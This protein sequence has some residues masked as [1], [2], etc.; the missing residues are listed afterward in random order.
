MK[1]IINGGFEKINVKEMIDNCLEVI[2][3]I[4]VVEGIK[5]K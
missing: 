4:V 3:L 5:K 1:V 2:G